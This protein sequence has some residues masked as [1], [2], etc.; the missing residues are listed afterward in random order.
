MHFSKYTW[1]SKCR[2][3]GK[4]ENMLVG[5]ERLAYTLMYCNRL[6]AWWL[7]QSQLATLLSSL[8]ARRW[9]G[10]QNLGRR[11]GTSKIHLSPPMAKA[12][13]QCSRRCCIDKLGVFHA[14]QTSMCLDHIW[15]KG[16][17]M[18]PS[19]WLKPSSKIFYWPFQ[20]VGS[21]MLFLFCF[22]VMVS[23]ASV[24]WCL[25]VTCW[26]TLA[27]LLA[28]VCDIKLWS[29]HFPIGILGQVWCLIVTI[30]NLCPFSY[31]YMYRWQDICKLNNA[32]SNLRQD[33]E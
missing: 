4:N 18:G 27:D 17:V 24:Y 13:V 2:F 15:T 5:L 6:H 12:A 20:G 1:K 8:I 19:N 30:P 16:E 14:N 33:K 22:F 23:C 10:F 28:H 3:C 32:A 9:V 25:V 7:T 26:E 31:V 11:F 21:F 29:C